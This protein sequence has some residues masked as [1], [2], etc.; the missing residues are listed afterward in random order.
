MTNAERT[1]GAATELPLLFSPIRIGSREVKNRI[2]STAHA[3]G[4]AAGGI[5]NERYVR[6]HE[7]KAAGGTGLVMTFGSASVYEKSAAAYGSVSLWNKENDPYLRDF[8]EHVHAHGALIMSQA[9]HMGRRANSAESGQPIQAPSSVPEPVHREIPQPLRTDEIQEIVKAFAAAAVR[10]EDCG[11]DGMEITS[12]GGHLIEQ[13]WSPTVNRRTDGYGGDLK[14]RMRFSVEVVEAVSEAVS[15][16]FIVGFRLTG[17]PLTDVV[18]LDRDDMLEIAVALDNLGRIDL[19]NISGG[20]GATF[21][22]QAAAVP[23]DF[24]RRGC[25]NH[26]AARMKE[27]LSVPVI[28]AG[29]NLDPPQAEEALAAGDC[30]LVAMTRAIIADPDLARRARAGELSRIRPCI[31]INEGCMGRVYDGLPI[32][33]A[34]NPAIADEALSELA[35]LEKQRRVVVIG[36]GPAGMEAARVAAE[37]GHEVILFERSERLGG[38]VLPAS[39]APDRPHYGLHAEWLERELGRLGVDVRLGL[40]ASVDDILAERPEAVILATGATTAVPPEVEGVEARCVTDVDL[41]EGKVDVQGSRVLV[42]DAGALRGGYAANAAVEAG[43]TAVELATYL[44]TV[45]ED[46]DVT[47]KPPMSRRLARNGVVCSPNQ[48]L[49]GQRNG[50]LVL[51]DEWSEEERLVQDVDLIVFA[52]YR[53]AES[54][55]RDLISEVEPGIETYLIGD[56]A[57]PRLLRD[58]VA[59]GVRAGNSV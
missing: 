22:S 34:V 4:M 26:L 41:L 20:T 43:A 7:R 51:R 14:G 21:P 3:T 9:T 49:V 40:E 52:G 10:L 42:Y 47:N 38:Q 15:E 5:L 50:T 39:S 32:A 36:G 1:G 31:A 57:A 55:L 8:A 28:A 29:R 18:G 2:V 19:F 11:W 24:F 53:I 13:F 30:D 46:L 44:P 35:P 54:K 6:Y 58:A 16:D 12:F 23:P 45:V 56:S 59:E 27:H 37:R 33:C 17:D 48:I 25:Y